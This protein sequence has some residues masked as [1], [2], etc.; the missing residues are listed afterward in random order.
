MTTG[1]TDRAGAISASAKANGVFGAGDAASRRVVL[2][3][4]DDDARRTLHMLL[5]RAGLH[6]A[7]MAELEHARRYLDA[8]ACDALI[9]RAET[10]AAAAPALAAL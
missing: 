6:V 8:H 1:S 4:P 10:A 2:L 9:A 5:D 7:A 3:A